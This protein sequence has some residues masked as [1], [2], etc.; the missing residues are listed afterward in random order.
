MRDDLVECKILE[1]KSKEEIIAILGEP[2]RGDS[3]DIWIY[4]MGA[5][6]AGFGWAFYH[7]NVSFE[8]EKVENAEVI[9]VFD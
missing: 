3:T 4:Q 1:K 9:E 7:L 2:D 5:T 6:G 8:N